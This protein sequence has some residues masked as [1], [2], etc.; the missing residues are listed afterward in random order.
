M[1]LKTTRAEVREAVE[2]ASSAFEQCWSLLASMK[3]GSL[4]ADAGLPIAEFQPTLATA[5]SRLS[6][7]YRKLAREKER[8]IRDK[9]RLSRAWFTRRMR[10]LSSQQEILSRAIRIG[11]SIGDGFAWFFYQNNRQFLLEHLKEAEQLLIPAGVGGFAELEMVRKVRV[12]HGHFVL[13]HGITSILRLGDFTLVRLKDCS[14]VTVG[15]LKAGKPE[16]G[17]LTISMLFPCNPVTGGSLQGRHAAAQRSPQPLSFDSPSTAARARFGRQFRRMVSAQTKVKSSIDRNVSF[18]MQDRIST[19]EQFLKGIP[20]K[21]IKFLQFG[22]SLLLIGVRL[23]QA[24]LYD[25]LGTNDDSWNA[26]LFG[27]EKDAV[28]LV[29][30]GR[31]DNALY[32][33]SWPFRENGMVPH[34]PGMTHLVW[35]PLSASVLRQ[36]ILQEIVVFT[37]F[38]PAHLLETLEKSG[39]NTTTAYPTQFSAEKCLGGKS[40]RLEGLTHYF[41]LIQEYF[42]SEEDVGALLRQLEDEFPKMEQSQAARIDLHFEQVFG[43][44]RLRQRQLD[45]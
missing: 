1:D 10:F 16:N 20:P 9:K 34:R 23:R 8:R 6:A 43:F 18:E 13:Y 28:N 30:S 24:I 38:N 22:K 14:V 36:L 45:S 2:F 44:P 4:T 39:F 37:V 17:E 31:E 40:I 27:L 5:L 29:A 21:K 15:E 41:Q 32:I 26:K 12:V 42:F 25:R 11:K 19:L 3:L 33:G 35:W 7:T